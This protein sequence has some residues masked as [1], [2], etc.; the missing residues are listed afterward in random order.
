VGRGSS[1]QVEGLGRIIN[2][3]IINWNL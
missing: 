3:V 2:L 1:E